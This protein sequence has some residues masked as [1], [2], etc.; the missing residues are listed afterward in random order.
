MTKLSIALVSSEI[1]PFAKTGGLADVACG[2][3]RFLAEQGHDV[4]L[5]MP[6]Y[7]SVAEGDWQL[8]PVAEL[9]RLE[10][11]FGSVQHT[12]S[13]LSAELPGASA[14]VYFLD[15]PA[16]FARDSIYTEDRDEHVRFAMLSR[17]AIE[18]CQ[19]L[20]WGPDVFHCNDWHAGLLPL[21][22]RT[23]YAWDGL[24][25]DTRTLLTIHNIGYQGTFSIDSLD[26]VSLGDQRHLLPEEDVRNGT[27]NFLKVAATYAD[28]LTT[29][30]RTYA[31]EIQRSDYGMGLEELLQSRRE[32]LVGIVNGVDY[33]DWSP[34]VDPLIA[35]NYGPGD[36]RGKAANRDALLGK[37]G[38][39]A[40]P[41]VPVLGVVARLTSQKGFELFPDVMPPLLERHDLR[42]VVLGSGEDKYE[43][44]FQWLRN[45]H[46]ERV[47]FFRGYHNEL[48]HQIEAGSDIFLMPSRYE[49][50]GLNQM[51]SLKYG[52]VPVVRR[53]GGLADTVQPFDLRTG[54]GT[55]FVFDEFEAIGLHRAIESALRV[56][57]E[58]AVWQKLV[59]NGMQQDFSWDRQGADYLTL[60]RR[61][62]AM[63]SREG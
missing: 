38:L 11:S 9:A 25:A 3:S 51:Y 40:G 18:C 58:P 16:L 36:M 26:E 56:Y 28:A 7:R 59:Q 44:Y 22:L 48:A 12:V 15:C 49:P 20:Q 41:G 2:L 10:M 35:H 32:V 57:R 30:S 47:G 53:T 42:L 52:T 45:Q 39:S 4:R 50:C 61:M 31:Q 63:G 21:Y 1:A 17:A 27:L 54:K 5:F 62:I 19:R 8:Q 33:S 60:Y 43:R 34:E 6:L 24:F 46:P 13:V 14:T 23:I 55:G 37:F 29:V